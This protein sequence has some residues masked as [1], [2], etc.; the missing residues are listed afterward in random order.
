MTIYLWHNTCILVAATMW[1]RLWG[2]DMMW[3]HFSWLLESPWPV[4]ALTWVLIGSCIVWFGWAEDLAAKRRPQLWPDGSTKRTGGR[5]AKG[6]G[7]P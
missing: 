3:M 4:L 7:R 1:D 6:A 2:V 5:R